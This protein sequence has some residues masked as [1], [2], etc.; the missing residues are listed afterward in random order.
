MVS[1]GY[2]VGSYVLQL[3]LARYNSAVLQM[4]LKAFLVLMVSNE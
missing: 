2:D 3:M 4:M 1:N